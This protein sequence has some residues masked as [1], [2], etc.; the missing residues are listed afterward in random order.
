MRLSHLEVI[1]K[2]TNG[3]FLE[4]YVDVSE[5]AKRDPMFVLQIFIAELM[6]VMQEEKAFELEN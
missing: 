3:K 4:K 1:I 5:A 2:R 6:T